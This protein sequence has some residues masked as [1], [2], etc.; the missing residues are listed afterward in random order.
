[1]SKTAQRKHAFYMQGY[2]DRRK[3]NYFRWKAHPY[4]KEYKAGWNSAEGAMLKEAAKRLKWWQR[5]L[6]KVGMY[7]GR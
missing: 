3:G 6:K 4:L 5:L 7:G 2:N 1:M